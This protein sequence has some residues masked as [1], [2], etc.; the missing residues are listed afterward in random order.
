MLIRPLPLALLPPLPV[1]ARGPPPPAGALQRHL[2][3][4]RRPPRS[5]WERIGDAVGGLYEPAARLPTEFDWRVV[6]AQRPEW[7]AGA[8]PGAP[9]LEGWVLAL[10]D[11]EAEAARDWDALAGMLGGGPGGYADALE[12]LE[13]AMRPASEPSSPG[14]PGRGLSAAA[15]SGGDPVG[16]R[17]PLLRGEAVLLNQ[18]ATLHATGNAPAPGHLVLTPR[19]VAFL[20]SAPAQPPI[21]ATYNRVTEV[22]ESQTAE[23]GMTLPSLTVQFD[24]GDMVLTL[25]NRKRIGALLAELVARPPEPAPPAA[26]AALRAL[27]KA[28]SADSVWSAAEGSPATPLTPTGPAGPLG[29]DSVLLLSPTLPTTALPNLEHALLARRFRHLFRLPPPEAPAAHVPATFWH[30]SKPHPGRLFASQNHACFASPDPFSPALPDPEVQFAVPLHLL[31]QISLP[32]ASRPPGAPI[33]SAITSS[34][35]CL[36]ARGHRRLWL[37]FTSSD[38]RGEMERALRTAMRASDP[39]AERRTVAASGGGDPRALA[40]LE[41]AGDAESAGSHADDSRSDADSASALSDLSRMGDQD[42]RRRVMREV[43]DVDPMRPEPRRPSET[44]PVGLRYLFPPSP[45]PH[46]VPGEGEPLQAHAEQKREVDRQ[47]AWLAHLE[48]H[49][50][51][52]AAVLDLPALR[53]LLL[54][55]GGIPAAYRP[56][57]WMLLAGGF[58]AP[59]PKGE[60]AALVA[61]LEGWSDPALGEIEK[62]VRRSHPDHPGFRSR[63]G[64]DALRRVLGAYAARNPGVGYAQAMNLVAGG[65]LSECAEEDGWWLLCLLVE[66]LMP[67]HYTPTMHGPQID[68]LLFP[69]LVAQHLP[70]LAA[71]FSRIGFD[72][73]LLATPWFLSLFLSAVPLDAG[74]RVLDAFF[75]DGPAALYWLGLAVM[76]EMEGELLAEGDWG[77]SVERVRAYL[78]G[79]GEPEP[80]RAGPDGVPA[81]AAPA[82]PPKTRLDAL[83]RTAYSFAPQLPSS[84]LDAQR[85]RHRLAVLHRSREQARRTLVRDLADASQ[86]SQAEIALVLDALGSPGDAGYAPERGRRVPE[87]LVAGGLWGTARLSA[88][89]RAGRGGVP[90]DGFRAVA[91]RGVP[92]CAGKAKKGELPLED[93]MWYFAIFG[94]PGEAAQGDRVTPA[95]VVGML[96]IV[97]RGAAKERL[98]LLFDL[99]D[100]DGDGYLDRRDLRDLMEALLAVAARSGD[101]GDGDAEDGYMRATSGFLHAAIRAGM[102]GGGGGSDSTVVQGDPSEPPAEDGATEDGADGEGSA[103]SPSPT[104]SAS[105]S[106]ANPGRGG[107]FDQGFQLGFSEFVLAVMAQPAFADFFAR[108]WGLVAGK[109]GGLLLQERAQ[110]GARTTVM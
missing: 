57:M 72:P 66:R 21:T 29:G 16:D 30:L 65:V 17:A 99:H 109:D 26:R 40:R 34:F 50:R 96:D 36:H 15:G 25:A 8:P 6:L 52:A 100:L 55:T 62:D 80:E 74:I 44:V 73:S 95:A 110:G 54:D 88:L 38:S 83:L 35:M 77:R 12:R 41:E 19:H 61:A 85:L 31:T 103:R 47:R 69:S 91:R 1:F 59:P 13:G 48:K 70:P 67:E 87:A 76:R 39:R 24:G 33:T 97:L 56:G 53:R 14:G 3:V 60:Y 92:W 7:V 4:V 101:D 18:P 84:A 9:P 20:P 82:G 89:D 32:A 45:S 108:G 90:L 42:A 102:R 93:R 86:L 23:L 37:E 107:E 49:G 58:H 22:R 79:V 105:V 46:P 2:V 71:H 68:A 51:D 78:A 94:G 11:S 28:G 43:L 104:P 5:L 81:P 98:R 63:A 106:V 27:V 64:V 75:L 10:A